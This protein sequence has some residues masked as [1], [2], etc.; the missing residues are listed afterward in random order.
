VYKECPAGDVNFV[1]PNEDMYQPFL[2][3][4]HFK[5]NDYFENVDVS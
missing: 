5:E 2:V 1:I 4:T 3:E